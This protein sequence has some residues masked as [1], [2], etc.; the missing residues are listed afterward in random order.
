MARLM[1]AP[2]QTRHRWAGTGQTDPGH[3][4]PPALAAV[5][6]KVSPTPR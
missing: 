1:C 3:V 6:A 5:L 2:K 4:T